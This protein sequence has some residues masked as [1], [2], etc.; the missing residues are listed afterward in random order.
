M[1]FDGQVSRPMY[2]CCGLCRGPSVSEL[3]RNSQDR[4]RTFGPDLKQHGV[5]KERSE[6]RSF[7]GWVV[8]A[9]A[10]VGLFLG[11]FPIFVSSF[12]VFFPA[13][14]R[15][16]HAQ[17]GAISLAFTICNTVTA[18]M[19]PV[20]G[21]LC[22]RIGARPVIVASLLLFGSGLIAAQTIGS[23]LWEL[24]VFAL[25]LGIV[26][27]GT[28]SI[29]YGLVVSRWFN[30][31]RGLALGL[32]MVG[33]GAGAIVVPPLA[34]TL[35]A[36][37]GW[38]ATYARFGWAALLVAIPVVAIFLME[39]PQL[40]PP[41]STGSDA[42]GWRWREIRSSRD[43][44]L[45]IVVFVL[46]S[47]SVQACFI[48]L[49]QIMADHGVM[50]KVAAYAASVSGAALLAGRVATGY[51]LDRYSGPGVARIIF[52]SAALG[53]ALLSVPV[54]GAMFAGAF[55]VGLGLGAEADIIAY[56]LGRHFGLRSF[57]TTFGVA[58]GLFVLAGGL[59]PL[60]MGVVFDRSGSYRI[61]LTAFC[62]ATALAAVLVGRLG[63]YRFK[64]QGQN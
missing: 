29:P 12:T 34:R 40:S 31:R 57:G 15:E 50:A 61:A 55:L 3:F 18:C 56:L 38:R 36:Q 9:A 8:V 10:A 35:I 14:V 41:Q 48:H 64:A 26:A 25:I 24:Y 1:R 11:V 52:A 19:A 5:V 47:A 63:P 58:F 45:M 62:L 21:R 20:V 43:F 13:F 30:R 28:N 54:S 44:W 2:S 4:L 22:D 27:P 17:R 42:E 39:R 6:T 16:F 23:E 51:F 53:I 59:G 33:M 37:Y 7:Y 32:M 46:V 60:L 49:T